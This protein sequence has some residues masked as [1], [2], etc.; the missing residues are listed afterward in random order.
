MK[1]LLAALCIMC[2]SFSSLLVSHAQAQSFDTVL[3]WMFNNGLTKYDTSNEFRPNDLITRW[4]ASKFVAQ[5][6]R[7]MWLTPNYNQ[8]SFSDIAGYDITLIPHIWDAC[9]YGLLKGS[10]W[11]FS[12]NNTLTEA[13]AITIVMR[14]LWGFLDETGDRRRS[15]YYEAGKEVGIITN[16]SLDGVNTTNVTRQKLGTWFYK[17]A[18]MNQ[19]TVDQLD[20]EA[21]LMEIINKIFGE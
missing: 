16:E 21:E 7:V 19:W 13:Q 4:E 15:A 8:C 2:L 1:K 10:N 20:G 6:A 14:S 3:N 5:A 18:T 11:V 9:S 12:P 17:A